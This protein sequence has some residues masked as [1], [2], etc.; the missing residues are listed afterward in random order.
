MVRY[1]RITTPPS[2]DVVIHLSRRRSPKENGSDL[3]FLLGRGVSVSTE[4]V[5]PE[6]SSTKGHTKKLGRDF[7]YL[8]H[9]LIHTDSDI[10]SSPTCQ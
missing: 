1:I 8:E 10:F 6:K 5:F 2:G 7:A 9:A 4:E 3:F